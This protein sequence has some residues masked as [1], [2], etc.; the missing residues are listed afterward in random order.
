MER[1]RQLNGTNTDN[2]LY[3]RA[4]KTYYRYD[5]NMRNTKSHQRDFD[6]W[7]KSWH[8]SERDK[9]A[10]LMDRMGNRQY[11]QRTYMGLSNG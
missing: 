3:R 2:A 5:R 4:M 11:S 10:K 9:A 6:T 1:I 8:E 7:A